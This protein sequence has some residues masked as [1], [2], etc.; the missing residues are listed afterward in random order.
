[1]QPASPPMKTGI[2]S[3]LCKLIPRL[4]SNHPGEVVAT[5]AAI[6]RV[7][8]SADLDWHDLAMAASQAR[9]K[10]GKDDWRDTLAFCAAHLDRLNGRER[11]FLRSLAHWRG[12]LTEKQSG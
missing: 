10:N 6:G 8:H 4:G 1:M 2:A 12:S 3:M 5:V 7:L 11:E 9:P